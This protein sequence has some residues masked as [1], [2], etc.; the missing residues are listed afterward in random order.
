MN[1][2]L[3]PMDIGPKTDSGLILGC[4]RMPALDAAAAAFF[5]TVSAY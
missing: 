4:M 1:S 2:V 5:G 3:K